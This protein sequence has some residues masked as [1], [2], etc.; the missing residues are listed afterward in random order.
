MI[1]RE[2][3]E[4]GDIP[5]EL[6]LEEFEFGLRAEWSITRSWTIGGGSIGRRSAGERKRRVS[7]GKIKVNL[8]REREDVGKKIKLYHRNRTCG[9]AFG[10]WRT[11]NSYFLRSR[12]R[13]Y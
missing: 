8:Q 7:D 13:A 11:T 5:G 10:S 9:F 4:F 3:S 1:K 2:G 12:G 6:A